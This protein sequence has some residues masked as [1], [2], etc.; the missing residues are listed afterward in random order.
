MAHVIGYTFA[1]AATTDEDH[2]CRF[3]TKDLLKQ[4]ITDNG[5]I[6]DPDNLKYY[7]L[8]GLFRLVWQHEPQSRPKP[9]TLN[10]PQHGQ[11]CTHPSCSTVLM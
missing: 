11:E 4:S 2:L 1:G 6:E 8:Q 7:G 3:C 9:L 5:W 10:S